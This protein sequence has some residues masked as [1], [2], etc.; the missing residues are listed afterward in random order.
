MSY[1][2]SI[3]VTFSRSRNV[4][5][6][7]Y[8][9]STDLQVINFFSIRSGIK[10]QSSYHYQHHN[11][12]VRGRCKAESLFYNFIVPRTNWFQFSRNTT[13][14]FARCAKTFHSL[15]KNLRNMQL[16]TSLR[17]YSFSRVTLKSTTFCACRAIKTCKL[18]ALRAR[19]HLKPRV[20]FE[21]EDC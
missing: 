2:F 6:M 18:R 20:P 16:S 11:E 14:K 7:I 21:S 5:C 12:Q 9:W 17:V 4:F 15:I 13:K 8:K 10:Q 1:V 3:F 19:F